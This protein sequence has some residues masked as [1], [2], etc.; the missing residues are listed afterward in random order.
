ML[1]KLS[2]MSRRAKQNDLKTCFCPQ[3]PSDVELSQQSPAVYGLSLERNVH[4]RLPYT[5]I[6]IPETDPKVGGSALRTLGG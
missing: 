2:E 3:D 1:F 5:T 4:L 6:R